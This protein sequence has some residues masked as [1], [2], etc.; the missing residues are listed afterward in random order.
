MRVHIRIEAIITRGTINATKA[1][2]CYENIQCSGTAESG[3]Y[4]RHVNCHS[5]HSNV[6]TVFLPVTGYDD[7]RRY[8]AA[9][10][11]CIITGQDG[12]SIAYF[13]SR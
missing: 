5:S 9:Y 4:L 8:F 2:P 6:L 12:S 13:F 11:A 1:P 10:V 7:T 3:L